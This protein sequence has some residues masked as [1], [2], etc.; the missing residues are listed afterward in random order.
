M[1]ENRDAKY[2]KEFVL[3]RNNERKHA[4][5]IET[6]NEHSLNGAFAEN[7]QRA[8][9]DCSQPHHADRQC[10]HAACRKDQP[11]HSLIY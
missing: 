7:E 11:N 10:G 8:E 3:G 4:I 6:E 2:V 5:D 1:G 9:H